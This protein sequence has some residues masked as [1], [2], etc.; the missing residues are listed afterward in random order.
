MALQEIQKM[1]S[2]H[3]F[4]KLMH[5]IKRMAK[6]IKIVMEEK[7]HDNRQTLLGLLADEGD[8]LAQD[9]ADMKEQRIN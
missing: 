1:L 7:D 6:V 9:I 8:R 5:D 3:E 2:V 4:D